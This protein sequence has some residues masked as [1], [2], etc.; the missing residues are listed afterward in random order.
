[1]SYYGKI[2]LNWHRDRMKFLMHGSKN[3]I[4]GA[5]AGVCA[6]DA[7][8]IRV[9]DFDWAGL[10]LNEKERTIRSF[11]QEQIDNMRVEAGDILLEKSGGGEKTPVGRVVS[12]SGEGTA[13][14]SNFVARIRPNGRVVSRF[15]LY[16][17]ASQYMS[18]F[19][20]QFIKQNTGIQN[21]DDTSW[22]SS[23]AW[24]PDLMTQ[25]KISMFLDNETTRIDAL[26]EKNERLIAL[27]DEKK[28][29]Y[30]RE[31]FMP[32]ENDGCRLRF[33]ADY[34]KGRVTAGNAKDEGEIPLLTAEYVRHGQAKLFINEAQPDVRTGD[35][36]ILWD[37]AGAGDI[38][39]GRHGVLSSTLARFIP[40]SKINPEYLFYAL[41][42]REGILKDNAQGMGIPHVDGKVLKNLIVKLPSLDEQLHMATMA[43][44]TLEQLTLLA[45]KTKKMNELLK[46]KR[47]ALITAAVTG[48]IEIPAE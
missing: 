13:V 38:L 14:T 44:K 9:S 20:H 43:R 8:C 6:E 48:Q 42:A 34:Q 21:L 28:S 16:L 7:I 33:V 41:K 31:H 35:V 19:S 3:G 24:L 4:W 30:L 22:F 25:N 10:R 2:P 12:Y 29:A 32:S 17:I 39:Q 40:T 5:E 47:S 45:E 1:M 37:G 26:I 15:L 11:T 27:V 46:E 23:E 18:G 36:L